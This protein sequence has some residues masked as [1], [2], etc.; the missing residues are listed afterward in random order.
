VAN[1]FSKLDTYLD[2]F[3]KRYNEALSSFYLFDALQKSIA[4]NVTPDANE[5]TQIY[6]KYNTFF[7]MSKYALNYHFLI[8]LSKMFD[9]AEK[10]L[11]IDK[12]INFVSTNRKS[13]TKKEFLEHKVN[14]PIAEELAKRYRRISNRELLSL[15][16][17]LVN[18]KDIIARL[19]KY[20]NQNLAHDD[21]KK[22][23]I[24]IT[25]KEILKLFKILEN[26]LNKFYYKF[27]FSVNSFTHVQKNCEND[28]KFLLEDLKRREVDRKKEIEDK[29][30]IKI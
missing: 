19:A 28:V 24:K 9:N 20:R 29:Y 30:G 25:R 18:N 17:Q 2:K 16:K 13:F 8:E 7:V 1:H 27:D 5:N 4:T 10:S 23:T 15:K 22:H 14:H 11:H 6:R 3:R 26:L 12:I 21:I